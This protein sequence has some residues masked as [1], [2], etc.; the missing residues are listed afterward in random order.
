M[1]PLLALILAVTVTAQTP[2]AKLAQLNQRD[3]STPPGTVSL[4]SCTAHPEWCRLTIITA[5]PVDEHGC[6]GDWTGYKWDE[7]V[8][9]CAIT[10]TLQSP[11]DRPLS[12]S[13]TASD[14]VH[15]GAMT[16]TCWYK[17]AAQTGEKP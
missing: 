6:G 10:V 5:P 7:S 3:S 12:C 17:P 11:M 8:K 1:K 14:Q 4:D 2:A 16:I 15:N 13:I 9:G